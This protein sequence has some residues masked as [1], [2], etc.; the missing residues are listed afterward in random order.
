MSAVAT[1]E[2]PAKVATGALRATLNRSEFLR[3]L[4]HASA[5]VEQRNTIPVLSNVLLEAEGDAL[6][7]VATSICRFPSAFPRTSSKT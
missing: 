4:G 7:I 6:K 2:R 5:I 3:A 1:K